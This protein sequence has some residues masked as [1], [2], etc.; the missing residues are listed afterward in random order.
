MNKV[1]RVD[2]VNREF[3]F[4]LRLVLGAVFFATFLLPIDFVT[5]TPTLSSVSTISLG[6]GTVLAIL[7]IL[8]RGVSGMKWVLVVALVLIGLNQFSNYNPVGFLTIAGPLLIGC[9]AA[10]V[11]NDLFRVLV[12]AVLLNAISVAWEWATGDIS[13]SLLLG[14]P[15]LALSSG[16][17]FR[18][19]GILGQPVPAALV[20]VTLC[21]AVL[22]YG[23]DRP[24]AMFWKSTT[25]LV[26]AVVLVATGTRSALLLVAVGSCLLGVNV[27]RVRG[28]EVNAYRFA[29]LVTGVA[30]FLA[31]LPYLVRIFEGSRLLSFDKLEGSSSLV[32][33][34]Y[35][36]DVFSYWSEACTGTCMVFGSGARSL[37]NEM[38][39]GLGVF[40]FSTVDN[41]FV[42]IVW[43]FGIIGIIVIF[44]ALIYALRILLDRSISWVG[45]AGG[46]II[47][48]TIIS[49]FSYDSLYVRSAL[50]I[51]GLGLGMSALGR[52]RPFSV[53]ETGHKES[54]KQSPIHLK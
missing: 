30:V 45:V 38:R 9:A 4:A 28:R 46:Q 17:E 19:R 13:V 10:L 8:H 6:A 33:R 1:N 12:A 14:L 44:G 5:L 47:V 15:N 39:S 43:D 16:L 11:L 49:G 7:V 26:T 21:F 32:N 24:R 23:N 20:A 41:I 29:F 3:P 36:L 34:A 31:A 48:L 2:K 27:L 18:A 54:C 22:A 53:P 52:F 40:G 35:A 50:V 37:L 51:F 25:V 42:S